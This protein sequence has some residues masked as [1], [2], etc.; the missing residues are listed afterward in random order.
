MKK[1]FGDTR[2]MLRDSAR[3]RRRRR[4]L[5]ETERIFTLA[6][7]LSVSRLI[8]LPFVIILLLNDT[9][10]SDL[11]ALVLLVVAALT[12]FL[13]GIVARR[14]HEISQLGKIIDP[15]ADKIFGGALGVVLVLLRDLPVWFVLLYL[16]RDLLI[17][18][19][20]YVLFLN[21]DL[22]MTSNLL[23][24]TTT[25]VLLLILVVYTVRLTAIGLPLVYLGT[26]LIIAS[27]LVYARAFRGV[28]Q[29]L[30]LERGAGEVAAGAAEDAV[31]SHS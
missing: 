28:M 3:R 20:S 4:E 19:I 22:V 5:M 14:R 23:G 9:H 27:G 18:T 17:L 8:L 29:Q 12:D 7:I 6:N 24:K 10:R 30:R 2:A 26:A 25:A 1:I 13:D 31:G 21:R 11:A 16:S 15:V